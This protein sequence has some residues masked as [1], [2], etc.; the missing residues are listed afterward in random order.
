MSCIVFI[1]STTF[2]YS[3]TSWFVAFGQRLSLKSM[4]SA[5]QNHPE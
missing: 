4:P 2:T 3:N 1:S 5:I